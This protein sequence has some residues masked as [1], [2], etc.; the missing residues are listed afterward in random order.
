MRDIKDAQIANPLQGSVS[1]RQGNNIAVLEQDN[2]S[3]MRDVV[4]KA[5]GIFTGVMNTA[6]AAAFKEG[7]TDRAADADFMGSTI[8][9]NA[10]LIAKS[11]WLTR[12]A[13]E[14]GVTFQDFSETQVDTQARITEQSKISARDGDSVEVFTNK[15]KKHMARTNDKLHA[16]GLQGPALAA[17]QDQVIGYISAAQ[18]Q[19]QADVEV[20]TSNRLNTA[21]AKS[22]SVSFENIMSASRTGDIGELF[23][24]LSNTVTTNVAYGTAINP[25][26]GN[27][28]G[29]KLSSGTITT[30]I[31]RVVPNDPRSVALLNNTSLWLEARNPDG[32]SVHNLP[33]AQVKE[34]NKTIRKK[35]G[36]VRDVNNA[37]V[38]DGLNTFEENAK[39]GKGAIDG[40]ALERFQEHVNTQVRDQLIS[41]K[42]G[43]AASNRISTL[44]G[45]NDARMGADSAAFNSSALQRAASG[46]SNKTHA[47]DYTAAW[48]K[49]NPTKAAALGLEQTRAGYKLGNPV[50]VT[51]GYK[52]MITPV[53]GAI[54]SK[55]PQELSET[56]NTEG[57]IGLQSML[58]TY[59]SNPSERAAML[60][61]IPDANRKQA[62]TNLLS[63]GEVTTLPDFAAKLAKEELVVKS[64]ASSG[65]S[66]R[67]KITP[68][69]LEESG[70]FWGQGGI[71]ANKSTSAE[72][73]NTP[74]ANTQATMAVALNDH[75]QQN[76]EYLQS[77]GENPQTPEAGMYA[78]I[79][80]G[81]VVRTEQGYVPIPASSKTLF[82]GVNGY[83]AQRAEAT[84]AEVALQMRTRLGPAFNND[85]I[86]TSEADLDNFQ[87][88]IYPNGGGMD[89]MAMDS[90]GVLKGDAIQHFSEEDIQTIYNRPI[91]AGSLE[92]AGSYL[93][94]VP[95][96][97]AAAYKQYIEG[98]VGNGNP[99]PVASFMAGS[100]GDTD[101][102]EVYKAGPSFG[103]N[104][105]LKTSVMQDIF[106]KEGWLP[107]PKATDR[108]R[109][110]LKSVSFGVT[111]DTYMDFF[112]SKPKWDQFVAA[113]G[114]GK[115]DPEHMRMFDEFTETFFERNNLPGV[116]ARAGFAPVTQYSPPAH[117][118][119]VSELATVMWHGPASANVYADAMMDIR[120]GGEVDAAV[121]KV[122]ATKAYLQ[123][124]SDRQQS[125]IDTLLRQQP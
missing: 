36:E 21:A 53:L 8:D 113:A 104:N 70:S 79:N 125:M 12:D 66:Q 92:R 64:N 3:I 98:Q 55:T 7:Q 108:D 77:K 1:G 10:K 29:G 56:D 69:S 54:D 58:Y 11:S 40:S 93:A 23:S 14:Q 94:T 37:T 35:M 72:W 120:G 100:A 61:Q 28:E 62:F 33:P 81:L 13:Y 32:S 19:Y 52:T 43:I 5:V 49:Q 45:A 57:E 110:D 118:R 59:K 90:K 101:K 114:R 31:D 109:P 124:G 65:I 105:S 95:G 39:V 26:D 103:N 18:K 27:N 86:G 30:V 38:N 106:Y 2:F 82:T 112:K 73:G 63:R 71:F 60:G 22:N 115:D 88:K 51:Q 42:D 102:V 123:S 6:N 41:V 119:G 99:N 83:D 67:I 85:M 97:T 117:Q 78:M 74:D 91:D 76:I 34:L 4:P 121:N 25:A 50:L 44:R 80:Q 87:Y 20:A 17:A 122:M 16:S 15:I 46:V 9:Q 89:V 75:L 116:I 68:A 111:E 107:T 96:N 84:L 48:L 47:D 24:A